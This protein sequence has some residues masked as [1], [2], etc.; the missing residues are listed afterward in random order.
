MV[1]RMPRLGGVFLWAGK[2]VVGRGGGYIPQGILY[3]EKLFPG[4][5][6]PPLSRGL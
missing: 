3:Q 5:T 6:K 1:W 2:L 4:K